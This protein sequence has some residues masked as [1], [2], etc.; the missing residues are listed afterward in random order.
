MTTIRVNINSNGIITMFNRSDKNKLL[1]RVEDDNNI[2]AIK[3]KIKVIVPISAKEAANETVEVTTVVVVVVTVVIMPS[4]LTETGFH[5]G[6][7]VR[8]FLYHTAY[9]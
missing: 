5:N 3:K 2:L 6:K 7:H 8:Y 4:P 9:I 1:S